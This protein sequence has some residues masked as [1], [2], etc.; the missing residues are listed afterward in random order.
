MGSEKGTKN[1]DGES[2]DGTGW[3]GGKGGGGAIDMAPP[4]L[5]PPIS[6]FTFFTMSGCSAGCGSAQNLRGCGVPV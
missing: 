4:P 3:G 6:L 1:V 5:P 2:K